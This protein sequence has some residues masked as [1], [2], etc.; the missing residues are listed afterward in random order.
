MEHAQQQGHWT[1]IAPD[2]RAFQ[3]E[4]PQECVQDAGL[5]VWTHTP[6]APR[7]PGEAKHSYQRWYEGTGGDVRPKNDYYAEA[8][9]FRDASKSAA[10]VRLSRRVSSAR[11]DASMDLEPA[12]LREL[13]QRLLDAAHDIE[14]NPASAA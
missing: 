5:P 9:V 12:A 11:F 14:A 8:E 7:V 2:G 4:S 1:L 13:A 3:G 6:I 10:E